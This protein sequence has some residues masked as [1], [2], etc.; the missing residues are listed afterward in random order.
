MNNQNKSNLF[1]KF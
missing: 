1:V